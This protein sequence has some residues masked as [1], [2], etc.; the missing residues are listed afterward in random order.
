MTVIEL[1]VL[2]NARLHL[3]F[4]CYTGHNILASR[5]VTRAEPAANTKV[6]PKYSKQRSS[7][8]MTPIT[9]P[10]PRDRKSVAQPKQCLPRPTDLAAKVRARPQHAQNC[11]TSLTMR[12]F[13]HL[14]VIKIGSRRSLINT[15]RTSR[16]IS[17]CLYT[18][19]SQAA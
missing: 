13:H 12:C 17:L 18:S 6:K 14:L 7:E 19:V 11:V 16:K 10:S 4:F 9:R 2:L 8:H 5:P 3:I 1:S 15:V